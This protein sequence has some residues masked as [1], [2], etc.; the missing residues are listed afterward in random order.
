MLELL[1]AAGDD[2]L[3]ERLVLKTDI[4]MQKLG[5][6]DIQDIQLKDVPGG[7]KGVLGALEDVPRDSDV[8]YAWRLLLHWIKNLASC[9]DLYYQDDRM[10][11]Q[12]IQ[13]LGDDIHLL[14]DSQD[15]DDDILCNA[16]EPRY[17]QLGVVDIHLVHYCVDSGVDLL[18]DIPDIQGGGGKDIQ[19]NWCWKLVDA[20]PVFVLDI[21]DGEMDSQEVNTVWKAGQ[22]RQVS[23]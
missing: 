22:G 2:I 4:Q 17:C 9:V 1:P 23:L 16:R 20:V 14:L 12:D 11:N 6:D 7:L 8:Y 10:D 5:E 21:P 3:K 18:E 15:I 19:G 13:L